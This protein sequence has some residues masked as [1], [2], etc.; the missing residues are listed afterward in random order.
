M[1][2]NRTKIQNRSQMRQ[3]PRFLKGLKI[4]LYVCSSTIQ[5][6]RTCFKPLQ[7]K[8]NSEK[9]DPQKGITAGFQEG[10]QSRGFD[11]SG[12][13]LFVM[14]AESTLPRVMRHAPICP[15]DQGLD[16]FGRWQMCF[17][18]FLFPAMVDSWQAFL[19][20]LQG[21]S[22][23]AI[24]QNCGKL[25]G[26]GNSEKPPDFFVRH[27]MIMSTNEHVLTILPRAFELINLVSFFFFYISPFS[28]A[29][30]FQFLKCFIFW[31]ASSLNPPV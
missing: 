21:R 14:Q 8:K 26:K 4:Q 18:H 25:R 1:Q 13:S 5:Y 22:Q 9:S 31:H 19:I 28:Y 17:N 12:P 27:T 20:Y 10:Q 15:E 6:R 11:S 24:P 7:A 29:D 3:L 2:S 23:A 16:Y 30:F